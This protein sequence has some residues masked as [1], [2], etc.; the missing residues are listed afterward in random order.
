VS[1]ANL[2]KNEGQ[3]KPCQALENEGDGM[4]FALIN[5]GIGLFLW[6]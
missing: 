5:I 3:E 2:N 1:W 6:F 4:W